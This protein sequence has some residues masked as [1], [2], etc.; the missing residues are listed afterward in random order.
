MFL[1]DRSDRILD[2]NAKAASLTGYTRRFLVSRRFSDILAC[3]SH[4]VRPFQAPVPARTAEIRGES[5]L[6]RKDGTIVLIEIAGRRLAGGMVHAI[7]RDISRRKQL[8]TQVQLARQCMDRAQVSILIVD[9]DGRIISANVQASEWLDPLSRKVVGKSIFGFDKELTESRWI[10][11]RDHL[12][13]VGTAT[14][15]MNDGRSGDSG[16]YLVVKANHMRI[17]TAHFFLL[18]ARDAAHEKRTE[19]ALRESEQTLRSFHQNT[20]MGLYRSTPDGHIL[21]AN[22][23]LL[24]ML[25]YDTFEELAKRNL[26]KEGYEPSYDRRQFLNIMARDGQ[27]VGHEAQWKRRDGTTIWVREGA[28]AV[29]DAQGKTVY[30]DGTVEDVTERKLAELRLRASLEEKETLLKEV[31]HRVKNNLQIISSLLNLQANEIADGT[32]FEMFKESQN[33]IRSLAMVHEKLYQAQN[34]ALVDFLDY[35]Q[36]VTMQL[37][38]SYEREGLSWRVDGEEVFLG[39]DQAIPCGLIVNELI[40][41]AMKHAFVG[42]KSGT[43]LVNLAKLADGRIEMRVQDDGVG[44]PPEKDFREAP[45]MGMVLIM[46]LV[47]QLDASIDLDCTGGTAFTVRFRPHP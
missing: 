9:A 4:H 39:I 33:R 10:E 28:R 24:Q 3:D 27:V 45:S 44:F 40:S 16:A 35:L 7:V 1:I 8:E 18:M 15:Q 38:R 46:S 36:S 47:D 26:T 20:L 13:A 6:K 2:A 34:L 22:P 31:H 29:C 5:R 19:E 11:L 25:G 21:M 14:V 43:L 32:L 23:A 41:N 12:C 37:A 42:R 30:F 17:G